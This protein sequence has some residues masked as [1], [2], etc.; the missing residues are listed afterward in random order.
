M[1]SYTFTEPHPTVPANSIT[2]SGR[3]GA[4][5]HFRAPS[6]TT[7]SAGVPSH[8]L[9]TVRTS[10]SSVKATPA[11]RFYSGRGGAGNAHAACEKPVLSFDDEYAAA[12]ARDRA[13][14]GFVGRGGAGNAVY[15]ASRSAAYVEIGG[16]DGKSKSHR[17]GD[18]AGSV[19]SSRRDSSSTDGGESVR[20]GGFWRT[21]SRVAS[22][23]H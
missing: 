3:G 1:P 5:N 10:A 11:R 2:H 9:C 14:S 23:R 15:S 7:P 6:Q 4:G 21:L 17:G 12:A 19:A 22:H 18:D 20:S 13:S 16:S 8:E